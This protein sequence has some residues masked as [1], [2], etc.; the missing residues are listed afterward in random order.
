LHGM[1]AV[2]A[3]R[4][5]PPPTHPH[6]AF[7]EPQHTGQSRFRYPHVAGPPDQ[8]VAT[9]ENLGSLD[10]TRP[11]VAGPVCRPTRTT[12]GELLWGISTCGRGPGLDRWEGR[13]G[14]VTGRP[15]CMG[16]H[17]HDDGHAVCGA[18]AHVIYIFIYGDSM[19]RLL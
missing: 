10:P 17:A 9:H 4:A 19:G 1:R 16:A 3:M 6:P 8:Q 7:P 14:D 5:M 12:A 15:V 13:C 2:R 18:S 11:D